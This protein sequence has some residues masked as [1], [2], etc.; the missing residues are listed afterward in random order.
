MGD[1]VNTHFQSNQTRNENIPCK[2]LS[3]IM[4]DS[5]IKTNKK[6]YSQTFLEEC[7]YEVEKV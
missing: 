1:K 7:K 3:L 5:V 2:W 6:Y 4:V